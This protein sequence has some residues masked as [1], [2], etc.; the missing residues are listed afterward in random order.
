ME[1]EKEE[2]RRR[3]ERKREKS[4]KFVDVLSPSLFF[5]P[6]LLHSAFLCH[7]N[8]T[9]LRTLLVCIFVRERA[10]ESARR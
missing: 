10:K 5:S 1:K 4:H 3:G 7:S 9:T 8:G 2:R 6:V